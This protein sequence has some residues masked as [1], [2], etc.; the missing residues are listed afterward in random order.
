MQDPAGFEAVERRLRAERRVPS[1]L[2]LDEI[3]QHIHARMDRPG[4]QRRNGF[5][6]SRIAITAMLVLGLGFSTSGVGLA[7]SGVSG[8]GDAA[9]VQYQGESSNNEDVDPTKIVPIT[10]AGG[11]DGAGDATE[12][13]S[14]PPV[15]D[16]PVAQPTAQAVAVQSASSG[17]SLP[18]TGYNAIPIA[19]GGIALLGLGL[20]L[21]RQ[22]RNDSL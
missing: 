10:D 3:R 7:V 16:A 8:S 12:A 20:V 22:V 13:R 17:D 9:G 18:F 2:E 4:R 15:A 6:R 19:V 1:P 11:D 14:T 21:R 5:M